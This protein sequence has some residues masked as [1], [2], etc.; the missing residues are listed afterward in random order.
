MTS[1]GGPRKEHEPIPRSISWWRTP[2]RLSMG[3]AASH[4]AF[5]DQTLR[6]RPYTVARERPTRRRRGNR[7]TTIPDNYRR[8]IGPPRTTRRSSHSA[9][10]PSFLSL[11]YSGFDGLLLVLLRVIAG[12]AGDHRPGRSRVR[13]I[14]M[15]SLAASN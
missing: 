2:G 1:P 9:R 3:E 13:E 5:R 12:L 8:N 7:H 15:A 14:A 6:R 10:F 11:R 4:L